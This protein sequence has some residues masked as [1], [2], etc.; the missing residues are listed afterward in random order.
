MKRIAA[1]PSIALILAIGV[2]GLSSCSK[3]SNPFTPTPL[4]GNLAAARTL[5][6]WTSSTSQNLIATDQTIWVQFD[7]FMAKDLLEAAANVTVFDATNRVYLTNLSLTYEPETK[8]LN[9]RPAGVWPNNAALLLTVKNTVTNIT[10][11]HLDGDSDERDEGTPYDDARLKFYTGTGVGHFNLIRLVAPQVTSTA[12]TLS[13]SGSVPINQHIIVNFSAPIDVTTLGAASFELSEASGTKVTLEQLPV[14]VGPTA[15]QVAF[16]QAGGAPLKN[17]T[18]Y[19]FTIKPGVIKTLVDQTNLDSPLQILDLNGQGPE[20]SEP[21][22]YVDFLTVGA[23]GADATPPWV[24]SVA[25]GG[26]GHDWI[27][28]RFSEKMATGTFTPLNVRVQ[29]GEQIVTGRIIADDDGQGFRFT[30]ENADRSHWYTVY[31]SRNVTDV[32]Q[33]KLDS[34]HNGLGG[35]V[36]EDD[37]STSVY[38]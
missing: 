34:N 25:S 30:M 2:L 26:T 11:Q 8:R 33:W 22:L 15:T 37:Y 12:P 32:A 7:Q 10:G 18:V 24:A 38:Y 16:V 17:G 28:V 6:T 35:E 5:P 36:D 23:A 1:F 21:P 29:G 31:V 19:R 14:L 13:G 3:K 27:A 4:N 9:V 20:A